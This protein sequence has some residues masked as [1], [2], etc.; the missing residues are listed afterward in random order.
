MY[1]GVKSQYPSDRVVVWSI[2]REFLDIVEVAPEQELEL[3][4][5][6]YD[7]RVDEK[8]RD[9]VWQQSKVSAIRKRLLITAKAGGDTLNIQ[10]APVIVQSEVWWNRNTELQA[11]ARAYR[12]GQDK[13]AKIY[14]LQAGNGMADAE[15]LR[16]QQKKTRVN[17]KLIGSMYG[18][19]V[20]K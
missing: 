8:G 1:R 3:H 10:D 18:V 14:R 12:Q 17:E 7:R 13:T 6:R 2:M 4:C 11:Y 20:V 9:Q 16:I 5:L 15:M 19:R